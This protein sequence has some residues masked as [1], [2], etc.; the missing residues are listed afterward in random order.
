MDGMRLDRLTFRDISVNLTGLTPN[1]KP[2]MPCAIAGFNLSP[3]LGALHVCA[4]PPIRGVRGRA[5]QKHGVVYADRGY[6]SERH[7]RALRNRG[8]EPM[9]A[10][11]RTAHRSGPGKYRWVVDRTHSS[12]HNLRCQRMR[13]ERRAC[14]H[15]CIPETWLL[16]RLLEHLRAS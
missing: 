11:R 8:I 14:I 15:E 6:N 2:A 4:M 7:R 16:A 1:K 10:K 12:L 5:L 9:I 13:F 3:N